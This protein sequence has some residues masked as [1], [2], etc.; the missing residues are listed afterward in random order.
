MGWGLDMGSIQRDTKNGPPQYDSTDKYVFSY[1]GVSS[2]LVSIGTGEYRAKDEALFLKFVFD[3][4]NDRWTVTDKSGTLHTFGDNPG[5][6]QTNA[7]G[8]FK[9]ALSKVKDTSGNTMTLS[10]AADN[11]QLYPS[12]VEYNGNQTQSFAHSHKV[13]FTLEDR[14]DKSFSYVSRAKVSTLKR[15]SNIQVKVK[16]AS[17]AYQLAKKYALGYEY[18]A[19]TKRSRLTTVTEYGKDGATSL[20]ATTFVYQDKLQE[21]ESMVDAG[22]I[23]RM[24]ASDDYDFVRSSTQEE[25]V[26]DYLDVDGDAIHDRLESTSTNANWN[27]QY[28]TGTGFG[29]LVNFY[30][31]LYVPDSTPSRRHIA[32]TNSSKQQVTDLAD[33]NA[34]GL[35]DRVLSQD[36]NTSWTVQRNSNALGFESSNSSWGAI[37]RMVSNTNYDHIR[38]S[39]VWDLTGTQVFVDF[40]DLNGDGLPDRV[41]AESGNSTW[42]VQ[43]NTGSGFS[44]MQS[45]A[46]ADLMTSGEPE[47]YAIRLVNNERQT[48]VDIVDLNG[49][50]LPD[51]IQAATNNAYWKVQWNTGAG[52]SPLEDLAPSSGSNPTQSGTSSGMRTPQ[53]PMSRIC[54]T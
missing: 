32:W 37:S 8:T 28:G 21:F 35:P 48:R 1:Q 23:L 15:L 51:R 36:N 20:P 16:D 43:W 12:A 24:S 26:V 49:D 7:L 52:F 11:G 47:R 25:T 17:G 42:K 27:I 18:S 30:G 50:G 13:E 2:E 9:W 45:W 5:S 6:R 4:T 40:F 41:M 39:P 19:A 10:Y 29:L 31:T 53:E 14:D 46:G 54:S 33:I 22:A 3:S 34:D 44:S 38:W